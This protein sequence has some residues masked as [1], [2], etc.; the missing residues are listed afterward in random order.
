MLDGREGL[1]EP[2]LDGLRQVVAKLLELVQAALQILALRRQLLQAL[3]L[4]VV[5]LLRERVHL[6]ERLTPALA[7]V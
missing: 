1:G 2:R 4:G 3:L 5:L 7:A 6:A